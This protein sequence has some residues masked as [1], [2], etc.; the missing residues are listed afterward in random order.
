MAW[1]AASSE[2]LRDIPRQ[3]TGLSALNALTLLVRLFENTI[4]DE[5]S[6]LD[7]RLDFRLLF[8]TLP[9]GLLVFQ[10][11]QVLASVFDPQADRRVFVPRSFESAFSVSEACFP[12]SFRVWLS[13]RRLIPSPVKGPSSVL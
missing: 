3:P 6:V 11:R 13:S 7:G 9:F 4:Q 8:R 10:I 12:N 1:L 2:A 5:G